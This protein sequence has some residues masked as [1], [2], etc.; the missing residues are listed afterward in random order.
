M[1]LKNLIKRNLLRKIQ[2]QKT[3]TPKAKDDH[4]KILEELTTVVPEIPEDIPCAIIQEVPVFPGCEKYKTNEDR[5]KCMN[6]RL[7]RFI[8]KNFDSRLGQEL[9]ID[10]WNKIMTQFKVNHKGEVVFL[11]ARAPHPKLEKEAR[12]VIEKLPNMKPGK[13][14]G[15]PVNVIFGLPINFQVK[16]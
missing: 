12:R 2:R 14:K 8:R 15:I 11:G 3:I 4:S 16:N 1:T 13:H 6:A 7:N 5:K 9:G 10:G